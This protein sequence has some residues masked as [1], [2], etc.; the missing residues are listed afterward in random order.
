MGAS[1]P[2]SDDVTILNDSELWRR[3]P[4]WQW[5]PDDQAPS[6]H[7]P[8]S[9]AFND[10]ELSVVLAV[11]CTGGLATL[12]KGHDRFGVVTFTVGEIRAFGWGIVRKPDPD[13]PGHCHVTGKKTHGQRS[14]LAKACR[15][16]RAPHAN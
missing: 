11:E 4:I 3:I 7:R 2:P 16:L 9:D 5:V 8:S 14:R 15:I 10:P 6:G 13:L 12:L 1:G